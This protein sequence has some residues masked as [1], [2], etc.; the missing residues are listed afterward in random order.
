[1]A[2]QERAK[3]GQPA[4]PAPT[5]TAPP[6]PAMTAPPAPTS[7]APP[8]PDI[9]LLSAPS[10]PPAFDVA[11]LPPQA[12]PPAFETSLLPPVSAPPAVTWD[13]HAIAPPAPSAPDFG[14]LLAHE[15]PLPTS[16]APAP[17]LTP[18]EEAIQAIM[19]IE[20]LSDS[21][22][23]A[24]ITEA[25]QALAAMKPAAA[26]KSAAQSAADAFE[27]RSFSAN[28]QAIGGIGGNNAILHG[29]ERSQAAIRN[30]T[31]KSIQCLSCQH[32]MQVTPEAEYMNC[33]VCSTVQRVEQTTTSSSSGDAQM[34]ADMKLAEQLQKEEY[35][36]AEQQRASE[37]RKKEATKNAASGGSWMEWLGLSGT[38]TTT[39]AP[40]RPNAYMAPGSRTTNI[41]SSTRPSATVA[42]PQPIFACVTDSIN[43][44]LTSTLAA[45]P[46]NVD[47]SSL[48]MPSVDRNEQDDNNEA[49]GW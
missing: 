34:D 32:W 42:T 33:P 40:E 41:G 23:Q 14:D 1:M 45:P 9:D 26:P 49:R 10:A 12:P 21:E 38:T 28:V 48:L 47:S 39:N 46:D 13:P 18:E 24:M 19:S 16:P 7:A 27:S 30:G 6:A 3:Q 22:K 29:P 31:A 8:A 11:A 20:G 36:T 4:A 2:A 15:A 44:A 37:R 43:T 25:K 17:S 5:T 35:D